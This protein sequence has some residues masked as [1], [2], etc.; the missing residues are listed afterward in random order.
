MLEL[1]TKTISK[2]DSKAIDAIPVKNDDLN[3]HTQAREASSTPT[4]SIATMAA[5]YEAVLLDLKSSRRKTSRSVRSKA[6]TSTTASI[7]QT[8]MSKS[9]R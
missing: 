9:I 4:K 6:C 5:H 7:T 2:L 3:G 1:P 8:A